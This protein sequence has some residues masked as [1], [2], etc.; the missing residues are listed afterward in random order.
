[1]PRRK[2]R[3]VE[4]PSWIENFLEKAPLGMLAIPGEDSPLVNSN[5]FVYER[6][7]RRI[8]LHT[9]RQGSTRQGAEEPVAAAFAVSE[10]GRLLPADTAL[11]FSVEYAGVVAFGQLSVVR[12]PEEGFRVGAEPRLEKTFGYQFFS[13][14]TGGF[15][16]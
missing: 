4:D 7:S 14:P 8:Y 6:E 16:R 5:L 1:M 9:A 3:G 11:E 15:R 10:M 12:E 13:P 2:D